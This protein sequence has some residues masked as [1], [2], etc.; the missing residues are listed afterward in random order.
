MKKALILLLSLFAVKVYADDT[1]DLQAMINQGNVTLPAN[2]AP[3]SIT[4]VR[5]THSLNL[6]GNTINCTLNVGPAFTMRSPGVKLSNGEVVGMSDA[7][8]PS[9]SSA[10]EMNGDND[11]VDRVYIHKFMSY[12]IYGGDGNA[13]VVVNSKLT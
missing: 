6:N 1:A 12:A 9:G 13:P 4:S 7:T 10:L 8:S 2:H 11:T 5:L 3:Y